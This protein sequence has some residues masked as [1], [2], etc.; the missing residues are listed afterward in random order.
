LSFSGLDRRGA[1]IH[2]NFTAIFRDQHGVIRKA[3]NHLLAQRLS[4]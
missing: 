2:R 3:H 1:L 4:E